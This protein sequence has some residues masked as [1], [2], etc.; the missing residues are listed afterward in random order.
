M[1]S[2][3][4]TYSSNKGISDLI[5][6]DALDFVSV[7]AFFSLEGTSADASTGDMIEGWKRWV[8]SVV[9][10]ATDLEKPLVLTEI[11]TASQ[12]GAHRRSWIWDH[13]SSVDLEDQRRFYESACIAWKPHT[14]G[15]YWWAA[16]LWIL[17]S[18][19]IDGTFSPIRKPAEQEIRTCYQ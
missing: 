3:E 12:S 15:M 13:H 5:P 16:D 7:D 17:D 11:G 19:P 4:L 8:T 1:F 18:P 10:R 9:A 6:W 2:G 14:A